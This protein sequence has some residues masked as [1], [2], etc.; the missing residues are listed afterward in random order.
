MNVYHSV[1]CVGSYRVAHD[2][3]FGMY[4]ELKNNKI[5]IPADMSNSL[6]LLHSYIL[7]KVTILQ[8]F[9]FVANI[10][11]DLLHLQWFLL[12]LF[13]WT[14]WTSD[15]VLKQTKRGVFVEIWHLWPLRNWG[16]RRQAPPRLR[17]CR[18]YKLPTFSTSTYLYM[19]SYTTALLFL[20]SYSSFG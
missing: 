4:Q 15:F 1:V 3:L 18:V 8:C 11:H 2:L 19:Y 5:K 7:A 20:Q 16:R 17:P 13:V 9:L 14:G 6:T 12:K 10:Y